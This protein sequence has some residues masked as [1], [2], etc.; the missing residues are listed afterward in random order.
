MKQ[1]IA[2]LDRQLNNHSDSSKYRAVFVS[3]MAESIIEGGEL[4]ESLVDGLM[5]RT[6]IGVL[7][8]LFAG[9]GKDEEVGLFCSVKYDVG[10][11]RFGDL[12]KVW[13]S[14]AIAS[15]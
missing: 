8:A 5:T 9:I 10:M 1:R 11:R 4:L 14:S 6:P 3:A 13:L 7:L 2:I 15:T 12:T